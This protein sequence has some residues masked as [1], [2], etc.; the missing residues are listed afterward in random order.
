MGQPTARASRNAPG[1]W[2][3]TGECLACEAPEDEAPELLAPLTE[4]NAETYFIRQ[5]RSATEIEHACRAAEVCCV[6]A[7]RYGGHDAGI[8]RRLRNDQA[9]V[10]HPI[11]WWQ[12]WRR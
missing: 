1:P 4:E 7:V 5:P 11:R 3:T 6:H 2:Y 12:F 9:L 8:I 10:D